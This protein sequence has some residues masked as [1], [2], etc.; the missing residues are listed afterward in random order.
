[1]VVLVLVLVLV[2]GFSRSGANECV[3]PIPSGCA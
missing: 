1:L 2:L 3:F